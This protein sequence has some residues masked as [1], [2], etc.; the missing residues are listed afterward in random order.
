MKGRK[1]VA[2][3]G[4]KAVI[5]AD[6]YRGIVSTLLVIGKGAPQV[7]TQR[8]EGYRRVGS[9]ACILFGLQAVFS[10]AAG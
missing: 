2:V 7:G 3:N 9:A 10:L 4:Q 6:R 8:M 5:L 1:T